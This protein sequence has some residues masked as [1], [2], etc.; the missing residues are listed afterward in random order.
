[1]GFSWEQSF[2]GGNPTARGVIGVYHHGVLLV[3]GGL[4]MAVLYLHMVLWE[5]RTV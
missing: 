1:M 4:F 3:C 5:I 2:D